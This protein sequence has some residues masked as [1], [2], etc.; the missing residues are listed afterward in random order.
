M[1][2]WTR[3]YAATLS[4]RGGSLAGGWPQPALYTRCRRWRRVGTQVPPRV[5]AGNAVTAFGER[6][7][8]HGAVRAARCGRP[9]SG[10]A[11]AGPTSARR[12]AAMIEPAQASPLYLRDKVAL[13]TDEREAAAPRRLCR[14]R[15][16]HEG[17]VVSDGRAQFV[18]LGLAD[19]EM[20]LAIESSAYEFPWSR[21]NFIDSL[22]AGYLARKRIDA[23]WRVARLFHRHA[24][25][26]GA[27]PAE[28]HGD[29]AAP[30]PRP[31]A[32]HAR[33]PG[34]RGQRAGCAAHLARSARE[35]RACAEVYRRYGFREV[36][37]RRGYYPAG[38]LA[39]EN[40]LVMSLELTGAEGAPAV[41]GDALD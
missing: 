1:P 38:A 24:G 40:A 30:A 5:V 39:R 4:V 36:G 8:S 22:N 25:R 11:G 6:L 35:Q 37:L 27:A 13:T 10:T 28:P 7:P 33:P 14:R 20:L 32:G 3:R 31:C 34:Q 18:P 26:A 17:A 41:H 29:A 19:V 12:W 9:C 21:G 15:G 23:G 16:W 2:A